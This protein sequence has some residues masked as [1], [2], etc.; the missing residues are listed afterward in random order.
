MIELGSYYQE[1]KH[2]MGRRKKPWGSYRGFG[3]KNRQK[4]P[5]GKI[6]VILS[7]IAVAVILFQ[8]DVFSSGSL[9][10]GVDKISAAAKNSFSQAAVFSKAKLGINEN[11]F[12]LPVSSGVVVEG[13][14]VVLNKKGE[15]TYHSGVDIKVPVGSEILAAESGKITAVDTHED[16]TFWVTVQHSGDWSTV[17]GRLG[18]AKV[19]IGDNVEKG[20]VLGIPQSE[21]LH[22]EVLEEG[23]QKNPINYFPA[24]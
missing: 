7:I 23:T 5:R 3:S 4:S 21:I 22:F 10:T 17:Y 11:E 6:I 8:T 19:N 13:Y 9:K 1:H 16:S 2:K 24:N 20:A 12:I 15:E 18:E 14:G